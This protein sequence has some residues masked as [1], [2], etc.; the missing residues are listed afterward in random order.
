MN[1]KGRT[2]FNIQILW[3][4]NIPD[5]AF[6]FN[7]NPDPAHQSDVNLQPLVYRPPTALFWAS[8][9]SEFSL[10]SETSFSL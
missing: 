10:Q 9:A 5:S 4:H 6:R 7:M 8:K 1:L 2:G 3:I